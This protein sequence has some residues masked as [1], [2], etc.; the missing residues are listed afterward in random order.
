MEATMK[1]IKGSAGRRLAS[2]LSLLGALALAT[3]AHAQWWGGG[4]QQPYGGTVGIPLWSLGQVYGMNLS[5]QK[6]INIVGIQ[7]LSLGNWN[8]M[9][10]VVGVTQ[11]NSAG[12]YSPA[13]SMYV[14]TSAVPQVRQI[15]LN[16]VHINQTAIGNGN[17]QIAEVSVDQSNQA[18]YAP[19]GSLSTF[20]VPTYALGEVLQVNANLVFINQVAIGNGNT[21]VA[22]VGVSQQNS[23]Q[24][25]IPIKHK[26]SILQLNANITVIN[27]VAVGDGNT[28]VAVVNVSQSNQRG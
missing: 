5:R 7:G 2:L 27:Q 16:R 15:N 28:Q 20:F 21:Q 26:S 25:K 6:N 12:G 14:P 22:L 9:V 8:S 1:F 19:K 13:Q 17:T 10:A 4:Q 24:V 18:A 23:S 11:R 3:P